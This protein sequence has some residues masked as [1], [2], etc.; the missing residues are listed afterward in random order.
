[1]LLA[2]GRLGDAVPVSAGPTD[3][4][5]RGGPGGAP[6]VGLV[7]VYCNKDDRA[8]SGRVIVLDVRQARLRRMRRRVRTW[9]RYARGLRRR[10]WPIG[11]DLTYA[12]GRDW[13]P[14]DVRTFVRYFRRQAVAHCWVAE[15]QQRGAVHFHVILV[16]PRGH[17]IPKPDLAGL[18]VKG[19][20]RVKLLKWR[21]VGGYLADYVRKIEQ[22]EGPFPRG[23]RL[24]GVA[25]QKEAWTVL[26]EEA[27]LWFRA[28]ALPFWLA[29]LVEWLQEI[30]SRRGAGG[31]WWFRKAGVW[32]RSPWRIYVQ[33]GGW[34]YLWDTGAIDMA[35][36]DPL[37]P[38]PGRAPAR[39]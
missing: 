30:P 23:L 28:S 25:F 3:L 13:E 9:A 32:V 5:A 16:V 17:R 14:N 29:T 12:P 34:T 26:G 18:W 27:S 21:K 37:G 24:F 7:S 2:T 15:L 31:W 1:M 36:S 39:A 10:Y 6:P 22:K 20:T 33:A 11:V 4:G 35:F 38:L 8:A 19:S